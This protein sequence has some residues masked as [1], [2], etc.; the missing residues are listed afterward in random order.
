MT[1][2]RALDNVNEE[3]GRLREKLSEVKIDSDTAERAK[4]AHEGELSKLSQTIRDAELHLHGDL[5]KLATVKQKRDQMS[6]QNVEKELEL[7]E[8]H[9]KLQVIRN[10]C[11]RGEIDYDM[12]ETEISHIRTQ[13]AADQKRLDEMSEI[14]AQITNR[15]AV[16]HSK[17]KELL[18]LR[19][20]RA[21]M[22]EEL[23]IPINIHRWTLLESS[24]PARFEK[25]KRYQ[26]LQ[27]MLVASTKRVADLHDL[28]KEKEAQYME[29]AAQL[30]RKPGL[31]VHQKVLE[32]QTRA[33]SE[34]FDLSQITTK[35]EMYRDVVKEYRKELADAQS[36]LANERDKWIRQKKRDLKQQ[37]ALAEQQQALQELGLNISI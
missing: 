1:D 36:R 5:Q 19:A 25:L 33:K 4:L 28:I 9:E 24:D 34:R 13:L 17:Q 27:A 35:L 2:R 29:L 21:A 30:R 3:D 12:K 6:N 22:E 10:Q 15:R 31:E 18:Q 37:Y 20:E 8:M 11:H 14:D 26:E 16:I 32:Y 23:A 7:Q